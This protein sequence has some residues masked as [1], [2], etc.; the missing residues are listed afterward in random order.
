[1]AVYG[2]KGLQGSVNCHYSSPPPQTSRLGDSSN[3]PM[4]IVVAG[5][6]GFLGS[7]LCEGWAEEGH[8]VRV[9][10]RSLSPGQSQHESGTG[11]PGITKVGWKPAG[12]AGSVSSLIDGASAVVNLAGESIG[13]GRWT[14]SRKKALRESRTL[15]TKSLAA[16]I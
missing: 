8:D 15:T 10:T 1:M 12:S 11:G 7:P 5:G 9:L 14:T 4:K 16:A 2:R 3:T 13:T 6:T